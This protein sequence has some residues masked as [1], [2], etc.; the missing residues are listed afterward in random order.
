MRFREG[1]GRRGGAGLLPL[2]LL[3]A[4][5]PVDADPPSNDDDAVSSPELLVPACPLAGPLGRLVLR[6]GS[7]LYASDSPEGPWDD[8][9]LALE[10]DSFVTVQTHLVIAITRGPEEV[11]FSL[12]A[13]GGELAPPRTL[14]PGVVVAD[15]DVA[16][17][18]TV[19][20]DGAAHD[21]L[22]NCAGPG[23]TALPT[24]ELDEHGALRGASFTPEG[25]VAAL[26]GDG[27][28]LARLDCDAALL[29]VE[30]LP[31]VPTLL[32]GPDP[33]QV[34]R[35]LIDGASLGQLDAEGRV[36]G[37]WFEVGEGVITAATAAADGTA[38][39][40]VDDGGET[41]LLCA[42]PGE[43]PALLVRAAGP[44][45]GLSAAS[46]RL[47]LSSPD[48]LLVVDVSAG[49]GCAPDPAALVATDGRVLVGLPGVPQ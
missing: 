35:V 12:D 46:G 33:A 15:I 30:E 9:G 7:R 10:P 39:L 41:S 34:L 19:V 47:A 20:S 24:A 29:G 13:H 48:G 26:E 3:G 43:G 16:A 42:P 23:Q 18:R 49:C 40:A 45:E 6:D 32:H 37:G 17:G 31:G 36:S 14:Y 11:F 2:L 1:L 21:A 8:L 22:V 25:L 28:R 4:C 38:W 5:G 44:I 27:G